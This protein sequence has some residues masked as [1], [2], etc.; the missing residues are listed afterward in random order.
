MPTN[1][2]MPTPKV[3][4]GMRIKPFA[5]SMWHRK[6][7]VRSQITEHLRI[8]RQLSVRGYPNRSPEDTTILT[9]F[10]KREIRAFMHVIDNAH[11]IE[12]AGLHGYGHMLGLHPVNE[13]YVSGGSSWPC[14]EF[15]PQ[16]LWRATV[17]E[18]EV[19]VL[20][21]TAS[22]RAC[23]FEPVIRNL[24]IPADRAA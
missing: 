24:V 4:I 12:V 5:L 15:R 7:I 21:P 18:K 16:L 14:L 3:Q 8:A 11:T 20:Q 19:V 17:D 9:N 2:E 10:A 23:C 13:C 6:V 1:K 22:V